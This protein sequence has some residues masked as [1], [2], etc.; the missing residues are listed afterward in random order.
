MSNLTTEDGTTIYWDET[1]TPAVSTDP[2]VFLVH[3]ITETHQTWAPI[4]DRLAQNHRVVWMDL[5]GHGKSGKADRYDLEAMAGDVVAVALA[6][7]LEHP[8]LVGHSLGGAVVSAVGS[9]FGVSSVTNVDQSLQL[10]EF[11]A[12][13]QEIESLLKATESFEMVIQGLFAQ[14]SGT[15]LSESEQLR[16][17][18]IRKPDQDVVLGVWDMMFTM[19]AEDIAAVVEMA[20]AGYSGIEVP[21]LS[22]FGVD[23]GPA[24][25]PWISGHI[26]HAQTSVWGTGEYGHYPHL[27][28]PDR[29]VS[30]LSSF[31]NDEPSA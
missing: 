21:Y 18:S 15:M 30:V 27:I 29:F 10:G 25:H 31:W 12:Q 16:L 19:S 26:S 4:I 24:Y 5:R 11:K 8:H 13:I 20:L 2:A 28:E 1:G 23:P 22:L 17:A 3:G 7:G 6:A 9:I 14:L